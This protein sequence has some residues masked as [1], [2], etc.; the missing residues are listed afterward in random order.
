MAG[1]SPQIINTVDECATICDA[2]D[3]CLSFTWGWGGSGVF[4][5][6]GEGRCIWYN[7]GIPNR[8]DNRNVLF[9][10]RQPDNCPSGYDQI[11]TMTENNDIGGYG[12]AGSS[13]QIINTVDEC[14]TICDAS[15]ECLS[16][17]WGWGGS[18]VFNANGEGRC[19]WY[20]SGIPNRDD[21]RNV[22]FC[23]RQPTMKPT[24]SPTSEPTDS[25]TMDGLVR[26]WPL[27]G[28]TFSGKWY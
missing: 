25:P 15:N 4:D 6:N 9:C 17:T 21:N 14:A 13:P 18:D 1:S 24:D 3:E 5:A 27:D 12:M 28:Q 23:A 2:S 16:F 19:I 22:L 11:G 26:G 20:N 10:A 7:R 8:D